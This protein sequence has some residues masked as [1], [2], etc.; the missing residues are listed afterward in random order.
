MG[1]EVKVDNSNKGRVVVRG[2][3]KC[4]ML[5]RDSFSPVGRLQSIRMVMSTAV[6]TTQSAGSSATTPCF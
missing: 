3:R 4:L 6:G 2:G 1:L 5:V